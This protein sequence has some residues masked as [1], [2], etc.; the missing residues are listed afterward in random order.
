MNGFLEILE[1]A[2][3]NRQAIE[4]EYQSSSAGTG[5]R[6][7]SPHALYAHPTTRNVSCDIYQHEGASESGNVQPF[8]P[9]K[10]S[11]LLSVRVVP[12]DF[13]RWDRY[14]ADAPR[15]TNAIAKID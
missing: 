12:D 11:K 9:F 15:Y 7:G 13:I 14:E 1:T 10:L 6:V 3:L 8:K 5:L 4:F 2:I